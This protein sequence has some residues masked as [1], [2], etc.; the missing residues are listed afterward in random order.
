MEVLLDQLDLAD[1]VFE[2][3]AEDVLRLAAHLAHQLV[4]LGEPARDQLGCE[5]EA[6]RERRDD[7][8]HA[9]LGEV[10]AVAQRDVGDV[11]HSEPVHEGHARLDLVDDRARLRATA[12]PRL[13]CRRSRSTRPARRPPARAAHAPRASGTRR[14]SA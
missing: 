4:R 14:G 1:V 2:Q 8:E 6:V 7:D 3:P 10:P 12:R 13:R 9:V 11:P 5:R